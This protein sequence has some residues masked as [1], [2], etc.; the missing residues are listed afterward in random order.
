MSENEF[1]QTTPSDTEAPVE[2]RR[3]A[4]GRGADRSR[5]G[6]S[7]S[8]YLNLVN[9]MAKSVVLSEDALEAVHDA[10]LTILEEIGMDVILPEAR[11]RMKAAGADVTPGT[12]RVRF[13][14]GLIMDM[15]ASVPSGFTMHAR[16]PVR[17]VQI[18]GNN[19]VFAQIASAPFV[20]TAKVDG[21][22]VTRKISAS[23]SNW[24]SPMTLSTPLAAIR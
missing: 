11:D 5:K 18:G 14:R 12:D 22:P 16:N 10:S 24:P 20:L 1:P 15:M 2:R 3:R 13:D 6:G 19:L 8:K 9:T 17:N 7:S 23:W 4:G 21:A